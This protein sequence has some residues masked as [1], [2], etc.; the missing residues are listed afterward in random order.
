MASKASA[1]L[2]APPS[3]LVQVAV[4]G[5]K[6][7]TGD[8]ILCLERGAVSRKERLPFRAIVRKVRMRMCE[9]GQVVAMVGL[10]GT[11]GEYPTA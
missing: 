5:M 7:G 11:L 9:K 6:V 2:E 3:D 1:N 8:T 4:I 10:H